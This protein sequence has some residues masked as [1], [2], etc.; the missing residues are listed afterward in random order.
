MSSKLNRFPA[1]TRSL[2]TA[3][4]AA[5]IALSL[6]VPSACK[7]HEEA[8]EHDHGEHGDH[9]GA[10]KGREKHEH[11]EENLLHVDPS[12]LRDLRVT[13]E[14]A[15]SRP[16]GDKAVVLGELRVNEDAYAEV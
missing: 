7:R 3:W 1:F 10:E 4:S 12:M 15:K 9:A 16:A 14:A 5:L 13:T 8:G 11:T 2:P 6:V